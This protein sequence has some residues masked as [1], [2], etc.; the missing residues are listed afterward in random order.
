MGEL[1]GCGICDK[2]GD[3]Q[4]DSCGLISSRYFI[5]IKR[6]IFVETIQY[7]NK[8]IP[9][10]SLVRAC[11]SWLFEVIRRSESG[12]TTSVDYVVSRL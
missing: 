1:D 7:E 5:C 4:E 2:C 8:G 9:S 6:F 10:L 11:S 3:A 12:M